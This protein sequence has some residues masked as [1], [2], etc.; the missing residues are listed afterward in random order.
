MMT[1]PEKPKIEPFVVRH[2]AGDERPIIKGNGFDGLEIGEC[3]E[4]A[5]HFVDWINAALAP[6]P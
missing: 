4:E 6:T 5:Q 2:Y 1:D 3:R